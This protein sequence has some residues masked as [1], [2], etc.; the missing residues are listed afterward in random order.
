MVVTYYYYLRCVFAY[1]LQVD[2]V[3]EFKGWTDSF[4]R[5]IER[6]GREKLEYI[7]VTSYS[8][9]VETHFT[10]TVEDEQHPIT[11]K[12]SLVVTYCL[13]VCIY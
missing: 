3:A 8:E 10:T 6:L 12:T 4:L 11:G 7:T 1:W 13:N 5:E 2:T 9:Q